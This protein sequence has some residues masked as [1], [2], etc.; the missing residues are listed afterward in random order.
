MLEKLRAYPD[1][2]VF[3]GD[4]VSLDSRMSRHQAMAIRHGRIVTLGGNAEIQSL[5]GPQTEMLDAKGRMVLPGLIDSHAHPHLYAIPHWFSSDWA[6]KRYNKPELQITHVRGDNASEILARLEQAVKQRAKELGPGKW[7]WISLFSKDNLKEA[8]DIVYPIFD[9]SRPMLMPEMLDQWA[10]ENPV[11]VFGPSVTAPSLNSSKAREIMKRILGREVFSLAAYPAVAYD[12]LLEGNTEAIGDLLKQE[13]LTCLTRYGITSFTSIVWSLGVL[14]AARILDERGELP[15]R[16]GWVHNMGFSAENPTD[17]YRRLGDFRG[18]GS[19]YLWNIGIASGAWE[20][21]PWA[22]TRAIPLAVPTRVQGAASV[23]VNPVNGQKLPCSDPIR[24]D[25]SMTYQTT[26]EALASG[27]RV[28]SL[29]AYNDGT[30]DAVF[31]M[32]DE[33]VQ[34]GK[35]TL[36]EVKQLRI[37]LDHNLIV[38]PDQIAKLAEYGIMLSFQGYQLYEDIK[39]PT[40]LRQFGED[41]LSWMMPVKSLADQGVRVTLGTDAHLTR[42]PKIEALPM[43]WPRDWEGSMWNY[44]QFF[45]TRKMTGDSRKSMTAGKV[46]LK[47]QALDRVEVLKAATIHGAEMMLRE[48]DLG[49]LEPGKLADF[50]VIDQDYFT[51]PEDQIGTIETLL[52]AVGGVVLYKSN[53]F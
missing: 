53:H 5:A 48:K 21:L 25:N 15:A 51:I 28:T 4:I 20:R 46:F 27:L 38:R 19:D 29:D 9:R 1:L 10:P 45:V 3:N 12:I 40:F 2:V 14:K 36:P 13:I 42:I 11:M 39:G 23:T 50:I 31:H 16:W 34:A 52:T 35:L 18:Q 44:Y 6:T 22:C 8:R 47:G 37:G 7:V 43:D 24:Y 30:Y 41:Y 17:F 33:L 26:K 49:T 32:L